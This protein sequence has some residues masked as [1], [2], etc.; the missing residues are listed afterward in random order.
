[1]FLK[2]CHTGLLTGLLMIGAPAVAADVDFIEAFR[3]CKAVDTN[4]ER[5]A[6]FDKLKPGT[7]QAKT[8]SKADKIDDFGSEDMKSRGRLAKENRLDHITTKLLDAGKTSSGK[9]FFVLAN[10]QVWR[11]L[12]ADT[13]RFYLPRKTSGA[14]VLI[15]RKSFG[16]HSLKIAGK[17]RTI[18]VKRIR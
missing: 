14:E 9:Y 13:S 15:K 1:M 7:A 18:K 11:Q 4:S 12:R 8:I 5:L 2:R 16:A 17:G 6:C 10:G 3:A